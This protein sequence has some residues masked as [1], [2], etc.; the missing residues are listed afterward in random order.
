M[1]KFTFKKKN[2]AHAVETRTKWLPLLKCDVTTTRR[3]R[4]IRNIQTN[5][6]QNRFVAIC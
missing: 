3:F 6:E 5:A 4:V 1:K 2:I